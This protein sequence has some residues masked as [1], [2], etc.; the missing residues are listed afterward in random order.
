MIATLRIIYDIAKVLG[1]EVQA[2][3]AVVQRLGGEGDPPAALD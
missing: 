2:L 1:V 3:F